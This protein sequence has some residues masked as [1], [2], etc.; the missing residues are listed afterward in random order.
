MGA[1]LNRSI[2]SP[3]KGRTMAKSV[4]LWLPQKACG[5]PNLPASRPHVWQ[6]VQQATMTMAD[7]KP[8]D[9]LSLLSDLFS[10]LSF[11]N[12]RCSRTDASCSRGSFRAMTGG[13]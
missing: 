9:K 6:T 7:P 8:A 5:W 12:A 13:R 1:Q 3:S 10:C 11:D 4:W 2:L